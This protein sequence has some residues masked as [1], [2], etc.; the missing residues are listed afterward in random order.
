MPRLPI[1]HYIGVDR[2]DIFF[3]TFL[4]LIFF[5]LVFDRDMG[6]VFLFMAIIDYIMWHNDSFVSLP[7][8]RRSDNRTSAVIYA[9]MFT[10]GFLVLSTL[11]TSLTA[12]PTG[13]Q[14]VLEV[15]ATS[16]P[17]LKQSFILT[18]IGWGII[19]PLVETQFLFGSVLEFFS[20]YAKKVTG[21][22]ISLD[23]ITPALIIIFCVVSGIF[24]LYHLTVK[25]WA[26]IPLLMTFAFGMV[27]CFMV[28]QKKETKQAI[29]FHMSLNILAIVG[30]MG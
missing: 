5:L 21:Q 16:T 8:E 28:V 13:L 17:I 2:L 4:I 27:S 1:K 18:L 30:T 3:F 6:M 29:L 15:W 25:S 20:E 26:S 11:I 19:I 23:K 7:I 9:I 10:A 14:S 24:A 22:K 12:T